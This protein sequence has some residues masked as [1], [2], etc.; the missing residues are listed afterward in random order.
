MVLPHDQK[1]YWRQRGQRFVRR[2]MQSPKYFGAVSAGLPQLF[3]DEKLGPAHPNK[4]RYF[5]IGV[6][7]ELRRHK[8]HP[9]RLWWPLK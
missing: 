2:T 8:H 1:T 3:W 6:A 7:Q 9:S 5:L 4:R